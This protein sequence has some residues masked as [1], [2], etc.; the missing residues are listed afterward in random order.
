[1][2]ALMAVGLQIGMLAGCPA[3]AAEPQSQPL[4]AAVS[5]SVSAP[6]E[7]HPY[8]PHVADASRRFGIPERWIWS[9][10]RAES[11]GRSR[12][13][14][15]VDAMGLMQIMP[16]TWRMLAARYGLGSDPFDVRA[17]IHGGAAYLRL[18]WDRYADLRLMLAA[19]NAGPGRVD[20]YRAGL[21][22]LPAETRSYVAR[23]APYL[24]GA[25]AIAEPRFDIANARPLHPPS[26]FVATRS[27]SESG[28]GP[29]REQQ[30]D[31]AEADVSGSS[32]SQPGA[33]TNSLFVPL[34]P[35][36]RR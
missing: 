9:V 31:E 16:R 13:F 6:T 4:P 15:P 2:T 26:V 7:P 20:E 5:G 34:S 29:T 14:S 27:A 21:R 10:M 33:E 18:M 28:L 30:P 22:H 19:Y 12:A 11:G 35:R 24:I 3:Y 23:L 32:G 8:A 36:Q 1:M 25:P 17:N